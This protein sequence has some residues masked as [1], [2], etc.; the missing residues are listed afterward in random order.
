M[1]KV[2]HED[3]SRDGQP[4]DGKPWY[5]E[6]LRFKCTECGQCCTGAPGYV[7]VNEEEVAFVVAKIV[8]PFLNS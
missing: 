6:G 5:A 4:R 8:A 3:K 7:W 2:I 1:L